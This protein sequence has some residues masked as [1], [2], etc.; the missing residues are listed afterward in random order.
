MI[1]AISDPEPV[2]GLDIK[3]NSLSKKFLTS[4]EKCPLKAENR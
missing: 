4:P 3:K 2:E 1:L